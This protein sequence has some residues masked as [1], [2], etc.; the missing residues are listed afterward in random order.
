M[1]VLVGV[2]I[3]LRVRSKNDRFVDVLLQMFWWCLRAITVS[4]E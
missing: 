2:I 4:A 1:A 3:F